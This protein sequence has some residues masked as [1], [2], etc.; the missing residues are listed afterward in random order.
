MLVK[1]KPMFM[2]ILTICQEVAIICFKWNI[3]AIEDLD[4]NGLIISTIDNK[5]GYTIYFRQDLNNA[6]V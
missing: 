1:L 4:A 6:A 3:G 5:D 2:K